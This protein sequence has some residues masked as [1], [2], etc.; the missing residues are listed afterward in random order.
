MAEVR[1]A[2]NILVGKHERKKP[3]GRPSRREDDNVR[4]D[5]KEIT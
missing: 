2:Y 4:M 3:F 1:N 5:P